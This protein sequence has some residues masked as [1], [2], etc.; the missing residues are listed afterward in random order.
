MDNKKKTKDLGAAHRY[1]TF[2]VDE[3]QYGID[4]SKIKEII[5]PITI[6]HIPKTPPF[7]KGVINL[8]GS[9]IPVVDIRLKFGMQER[10]MDINTAI[11]IYEVDK[12]YIGFIV[13]HVED[14]LSLN[15]DSIS[16][17]PHFGSDIDTSFI[18]NVAEVNND[19]IMLLNLEKIFEPE[20]LL[21]I[22]KLE[23]ENL[24]TKEEEK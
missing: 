15:D 24:H 7:V 10:E 22:S 13:D 18:E 2:F 12:V 23:Q 9:I 14:V 4:I 19:V 8:R 17:A 21:N 3:E 5:A 6:T 16:D 20:E 1:L 11:I